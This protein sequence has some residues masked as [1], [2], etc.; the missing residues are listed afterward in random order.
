MK[1][2]ISARLNRNFK[3]PTNFLTNAFLKNLHNNN[4][5]KEFYHVFRFAWKKK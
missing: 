3:N 4:V 2:I 5:C 1:K